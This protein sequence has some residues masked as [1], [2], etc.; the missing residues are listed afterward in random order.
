MT[1]GKGVHFVMADGVSSILSNSFSYKIY[2]LSIFRGFQLKVK[3]VFKKFCR[4]DYIYVKPWLLWV[5]YGLVDILCVNYLIYLLNLV[6]DYC[7]Y[8]IIV[9][10]KLAF[11]NQL[12]AAQPIQK[13]NLKILL[14]DLFI[15]ITNLPILDMSYV[16]GG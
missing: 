11:I 2:F 13:G 6:L 16:S 5:F 15:M 10:N 12:Q 9:L 4:N 7:S 1:E 14:F 8:Y 3:K